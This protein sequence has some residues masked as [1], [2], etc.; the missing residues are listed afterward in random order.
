MVYQNVR[1]YMDGIYSLG[2]G[3]EDIMVLV[4]EII[5]CLAL[6][7]DVV[8]QPNELPTPNDTMTQT[9]YE[10]EKERINS[11]PEIRNTNYIITP[12]LTPVISCSI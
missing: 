5:A 9:R 6:L 10:K 8:I 12:V 4:I 3:K 11:A 7:F 1:D 2:F